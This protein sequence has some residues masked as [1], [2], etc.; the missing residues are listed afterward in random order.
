MTGTI[1]IYYGIPN[2]GDFFNTKGILILNNDFNID[3]L[4]FD[5]YYSNMDAI[6]DN[7]DK[8]KKLLTAED[9]IYINHIKNEI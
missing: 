1:P 2:I 5:F 4:S 6:K 3:D 8:A 9:N 7:F